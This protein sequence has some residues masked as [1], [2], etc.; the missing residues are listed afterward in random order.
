VELRVK[1]SH[2][3]FNRLVDWQRTRKRKGFSSI[4]GPGTVGFEE[5]LGG[6]LHWRVWHLLGV[7][8]LRHRYARS[9]FG[10]L[11]LTVS[12]SFMIGAMATL[13]GILWKQPLAEMLPFFG[14][15][16]IMW[17]FMSQVLNECTTILVEHARLYLNQK[18]NFSV[19]IY[20]VIYK[21]TMIL[22]H[23]LV[24]IVVLILAFG[25]PINWYLL[26][27]VPALGLTWI[28][29]GWLGYLV[30]MICVRYR[31]VI[32][33]ISTWLLVF[34]LL[35]PV[36]WRPNFL[37]SGYHFL[38]F[39]N[40]LAQFLEL[41]RSPFLGQPVTTYTWIISSVIALCGGLLSLPAIG[42]YRQRVIF[43]M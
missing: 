35:S 9:R 38:V 21:N 8:D 4:I 7:N 20:S 26:Q 36:M 19:S 2:T 15:G 33:L 6:A 40:P 31:D 29:M 32:Q 16:I 39:Y 42:R 37:P 43:W 22:G 11:W 24:I 41:L 14:V 17:N 18:M 12:N 3:G 10:Q 25:V 30:A 23:N 27:I 34:F 28:T 1:S 13:W 5:L